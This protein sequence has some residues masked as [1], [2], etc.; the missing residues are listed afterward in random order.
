VEKTGNSQMI[1]AWYKTYIQRI[2]KETKKKKW[3]TTG[4][5]HLYQDQDQEVT[6]KRQRRQKSSP[7]RS[8]NQFHHRPPSHHHPCIAYW[9]MA[10]K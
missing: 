9:P 8:S 5:P 4:L 3:A 6:G 1:A 7:P 2:G 10:A